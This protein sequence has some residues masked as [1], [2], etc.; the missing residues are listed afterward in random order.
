MGHRPGQLGSA[1]EERADMAAF[2]TTCD[3]GMHRCQEVR[4]CEQRR[5]IMADAAVVLRGD[6]NIG[7]RR[8]GFTGRDT[9]VMAGRTVV[10]VYAEMI[11][12][13]SRK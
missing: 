3:T 2:T 6:M 8:T 9:C 4:R 5:R 12:S 1:R 13:N 11:E 7:T 10:A